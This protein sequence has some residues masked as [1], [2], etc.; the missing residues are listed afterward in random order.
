MLR[1][2]GCE[3]DFVAA[4]KRFEGWSMPDDE[5]W[6]RIRQCARPHRADRP[7]AGRR[8]FDA[9]WLLIAVRLVALC[10]GEDEASALIAEAA[11]DGRR[12]RL[13]ARK[14]H[15]ARPR[16]GKERASA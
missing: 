16:T 3:R 11:V 10:G 5:A 2:T 15:R 13:E 12:A 1:A 4:V 9:D 14:L 6:R 7:R 8:H